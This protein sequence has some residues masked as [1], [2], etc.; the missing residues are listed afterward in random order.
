MKISP[1]NISQKRIE[2]VERRGPE[3]QREEEQ[4]PIDTP[5]RQGSVQRLVDGSVRRAIKHARTSRNR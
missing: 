1:D 5:D 2:E 4:A 3:E